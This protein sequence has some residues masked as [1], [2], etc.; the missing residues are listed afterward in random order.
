MSP[1]RSLMQREDLLRVRAM[2][3]ELADKAVSDHR[4]SGQIE[5]VSELSRMM[6]WSRATQYDMFHNT[7]KDPLIHAENVAAGQEMK[8]YLEGLL[9]QRRDELA[10]NPG[11]DDILSRLLKSRFDDAIHFD[12]QRIVTNMM[13][14]LVGGIETSSPA[15]VQILD[16]LFKRPGILSEARAA[17]Q[18]DDDELLFKYCWEALRFNPINPFVIRYCAEDYKLAAGT[19]RS[20]RIKAGKIVLICTRSAMRDGRE[21]DYADDFCID[22]PDYHYMHMGYGLHTCLG[23]QVSRVQVPTIIKQLLKLPK[24]RPVGEI[25]FEGGPFPES[26]T[27]AFD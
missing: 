19:W 20:S 3:A 15:V 11:L 6:R 16:Q 25:D 14:T 5:V 7:D 17:A 24:L 8:T 22:R 9:P 12:E 2:V 21:L 13:G 4:Q 26:Y 23:D 27:V 18:A 10:Q 1:M